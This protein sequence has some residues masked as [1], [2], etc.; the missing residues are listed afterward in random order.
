[1]KLTEFFKNKRILVTG[2]AGTVGSEL[3]K[4]LLSCF[5][6]GEIIGLDD[7]VTAIYYSETRFANFTNFHCYLGDVRDR[8]ILIKT[9]SG[10]D[11]VFHCAAFKHVVL[12]ERSPFEAVQTNIIGIQNIISA[13]FQNKVEKVIFT[14]SDKAVNPSS[15]MGTSKLMG[16]RLITAATNARHNPNVTFTSC[17]F[18]N[19]LGSRGSVISIFNQQ[20]SNGGPVTVTDKKMTRFIMSIEESVRL[21][22]ESIRFSKGGEVFITKMP[23]INIIDLAEVMIAYLAPKMDLNPDKI[24]IKLI[25][26]KPGEKFY[27]ELMN[28][29]ETRRAI[30]LKDY[31]VV[32]PALRNIYKNIEY[33][34]PSEFSRK[35]DK[36]FISSAAKPM[37]KSDLLK[38]L[39]KNNLLDEHGSTG[40][41]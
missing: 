41:K 36:P 10:I 11:I 35:V 21:V 37:G 22:I 17:R 18:G 32:V 23:V 20:I 25:G 4:Q 31:F 14:S 1:M 38:F 12:C 6:A 30:E 39:L 26:T 40:V 15:V 5:N 3:I 28:I 9:M 29:E 7:N 34:Y 16:E 19:V 33:S 8:D 27:E 24:G 13:A 2:S